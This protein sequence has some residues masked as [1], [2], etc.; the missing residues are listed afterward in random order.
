MHLTDKKTT[1]ILTTWESI[2]FNQVK[3][4]QK[5]F[6]LSK[7]SMTPQEMKTTKMHLEQTLIL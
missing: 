2:D 6:I 1:K 5:Y 4:S 7:S 3:L